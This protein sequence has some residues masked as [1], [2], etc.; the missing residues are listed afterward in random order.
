MN[1]LKKDQIP[2][3]NRWCLVEVR[4]EQVR[5]KY[6]KIPPENNFFT[7]GTKALWNADVE[8]GMRC[9]STR[10]YTRWTYESASKPVDEEWDNDPQITISMLGLVDIQVTLDQVCAWTSGQR[11]A[12]EKWAGAIHLCASDNDDVEVPEKPSFLEGLPRVELLL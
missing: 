8:V 12:A 1:D 3:E 6:W 10:D 9:I 11:Q 5:A 4:G 7:E 2:E